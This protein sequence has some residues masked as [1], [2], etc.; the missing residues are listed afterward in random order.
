MQRADSNTLK[1]VGGTTSTS[2]LPREHISFHYAAINQQV[3][4]Q[5]RHLV[6]FIKAPA[7]CLYACAMCTIVAVSQKGC[8]W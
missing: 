2:Y 3:N 7:L 4:N 1:V 8:G 6:H 5:M